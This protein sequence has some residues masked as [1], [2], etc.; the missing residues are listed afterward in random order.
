MKPWLWL[1]VSLVAG[2]RGLHEERVSE[3]LLG[4]QLSQ[5]QFQMTLSQLDLV[6]HSSRSDEQLRDCE[7]CVTSVQPTTDGKMVYCLVS[8]MHTGCVLAHEVKP[9]RVSLIAIEKPLAT[10]LARAL[11]RFIEGPQPPE[12]TGQRGRI[13]RRPRFSRRARRRRGG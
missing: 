5:H 11:W 8:G 4:R 3:R 2:C 12:G 6:M 1:V 10:P 13:G 7:L 9:G